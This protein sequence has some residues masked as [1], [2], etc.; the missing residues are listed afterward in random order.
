MS[1]NNKRL[2]L[3]ILIILLS[4]INILSIHS[5][6]PNGDEGLIA[7]SAYNLNKLGYA[8]S[9][10]WAGL[11]MNWEIRLYLY[12]KGLSL[13]GSWIIDLLGYS[14]AHFRLISV[15]FFLLFIFLYSRYFKIHSQNNYPGIFLLAL[16]ILLL[17]NVFCEYSFIYR[18]EIVHLT[19]GFA[20][21]FS[22][23]WSLRKDNYYLSGLAGI[24]AGL[25]VFTHLNGLV[26]IV[27]GLVTYLFNKRYKELVIFG[28]FAGLFSLLYLFDVTSKEAFSDF[29]VQLINEPSLGSKERSPFLSIFKEHMRFFNSEK[30]AVFSVLFFISLAVNFKYIRQNYRNFLL[31][32]LG[33]IFGLA[34]I[35]HSQT[36]KYALLYYPFMAFVIALS[37]IRFKEFTKFYNI[38]FMILFSI[39]VVI[40][41]YKNVKLLSKRIDIAERNSEIM[42]NIP[43][44]STS[45]TAFEA[46]V[47]DEID[48]HTI[49]GHIAFT[50]FYVKNYPEYVHTT[51]DYFAFADSLNDRYVII[52][53]QL[54]SDPVFNFISENN[55][56]VGDEIYNFR[57]IVDKDQYYIFKNLRFEDQSPEEVFAMNY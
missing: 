34:I 6:F 28:I 38:S 9:E 2:V 41:S 1:I 13:M 40:H 52:D 12:H 27:A 56:Q 33:S 18:P 37:F 23:D 57:L 47:F 21:F 50:F 54:Q 45:V 7:E 11:G 39:F 20:C 25:A 5:R 24:L 4:L 29:I 8:K 19:L 43:E 36:N 3:I 46:F 16:L 14:L 49:H 31:M 26:F 15:F 17:N 55:M 53:L 30:E 51:A 44:E 42:A 32:G 10:I 48:N 35:S 22:I